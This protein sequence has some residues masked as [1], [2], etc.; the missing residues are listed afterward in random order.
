[1]RSAP[2]AAMLASFAACSAVS[3]GIELNGS[4]ETALHESPGRYD[5]SGL[6][7]WTAPDMINPWDVNRLRGGF[8]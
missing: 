5:I 4:F 8:Q 2:F 3:A 7:G 6:D 1:M